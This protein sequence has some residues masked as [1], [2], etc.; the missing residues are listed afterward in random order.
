MIDYSKA[1]DTIDHES[2]IRKLASLNFS[3]SSIKIILNY[4]TNR[5]QYVQVNDKQST[6]LPIYFGVPQGSILG[7][8]LFNICVAKLSR[9]I[10]S[11]SIQ[12]GDDTNIYKSSSKANTISTIRALENDISEPLKWSK[13]NGLV[14]NN[15]KLK[16]IVISSKKS[17]D[18]KSFLIRAK[19]KSIQREPTAMLLGV[20][21]DE[22]V[23][24]KEQIKIITKS[25]YN[26]LRMLKT[27]KRFTPWNVWKSLAES[28][29]LSRINYSIVV[30]SR[31][32][33]Y[34]QKD[35]SVTKLCRWICTW[36]ICQY[37]R[38]SQS[39]LVTWSWKHRIQHVKTCILSR[40]TWQKLAWISVS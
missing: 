10:A 6:Q 36:K 11:N 33:K 40:I 5:K 18:D 24:W 38:R 20:T 1:F 19:G 27:F 3:N 30:H 8:V 35:Y 7:P 32:P 17:N 12:Y 37:I 15:D 31:T 25:N 29:I 13:N 9:C 28:L 34:L 26:I 21:F 22:H 4:L 14:Y 39:K 16:S 23:T 2:L